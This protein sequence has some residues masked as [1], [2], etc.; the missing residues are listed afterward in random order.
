MVQCTADDKFSVWQWLLGLSELISQKD[1][2]FY[3]EK[4]KIFESF[5]HLLQIKG[6]LFFGEKTSALQTV[7]SGDPTSFI[8]RFSDTKRGIY[9][10]HQIAS[11]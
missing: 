10:M 11:K 6:W 5:R 9:L 7:A 3:W 4:G 1:I 8:L 2:K